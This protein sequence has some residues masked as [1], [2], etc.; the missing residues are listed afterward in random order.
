LPP[1]TPWFTDTVRLGDETKELVL[2][3][4]GKAVVEIGE[5]GTRSN[6]DANHVKAMVSRQIDE[7]RTAYARS[8][9]ARPRRNIFLGT[10]NSNEPLSDPT[11]NRRFLPVSVASAIN[12]AW[13]SA[14]IAQLVGEAACRHGKG[15]SFAIPYEVWG[16]AAE[17]QDAARELSSIELRFAD[18]FTATPATEVAYI[19]ASDLD[20]LCMIAGLRGGSRTDALRKLGFTAVTPYLNGRKVRVWY[21]GPVAKPKHIENATRYA[22]GKT[23]D[24]RPIVRLTLTGQAMLPPPQGQRT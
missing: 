23:Q 5:M 20:E 15:E 10:T 14:N 19:T 24:G 8:V 1:V 11:G 21:R 4:A 22:I 12:L 9:S 16:I 13:L 3:L 6:A 7:G 2:S 17:H 18:W